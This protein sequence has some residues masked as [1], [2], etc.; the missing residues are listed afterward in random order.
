MTAR[1]LILYGTTDGH[2]RKV[3]TAL[4]ETLRAEA[5]VVDVID[6]ATA[7][8]TLGPG[9]YDGII[10]AASIRGGHFQRPVERWVRRHAAALNGK[11]G[12]FV[13]VCL[14][15]LDKRPEAQRQVHAIVERLLRQSGWQ[16]ARRKVVAGALPYTRYNWL[17]RWVMKRIVANEGGDTD[18]TRDYEYTDWEDLRA[19][20]TEFVEA[21]ALDSGSLHEPAGK[22]S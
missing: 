17:L 18:T 3:A 4:A 12:A 22:L 2:T 21:F 16:A 15:I 10:V 20:G 14:G 6:A 7:A 8:P 11:V 9:P 5:C 1:V 13:A 19:F